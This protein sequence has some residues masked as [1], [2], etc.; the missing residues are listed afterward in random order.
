MT[1]SVKIIVGLM[2]ITLIGLLPLAA[3]GVQDEAV[4]LKYFSG[5]VETVEWED[6]KIAEFE[7][8]NPGI[9][10]EHEFQKD[11]SNVIK[12]KLASGEM[13]DL[14]TVVTQEFIDQGIYADL[15]D[16]DFWDRIVPSV[17]AL[18]TDLN[19]GKQFRVATNVTMGGLFYNKAMFAELGLKDAQTWDEFTA[20]L[21]A[22][23]KAYPDTDPLFL[24][25]KDSWTLGHFIEFWAHG[26]VKQALGIPG[27]RQAFLDNSLGDLG[28]A[29]DAPNGIMETFA[30]ALLELQASE[31][32]NA[33]AVTATYDNQK[34]S[35][36]SGKAA[37]INQGMWVVGDII[38]LNPEMSDNIGFSPFPSVVDGYKPM[39]L[40]AEDSVWAISASTENK[41]EAVNFLE[42]MFGADVQKEYSEIRGMPS[43]FT[44][45]FADWSPIKDDAKRLI[46]TYVGINF[47]TEA[48]S[49]LSVDDTG[50]LI[51]ELLTGKYDSPKEFAKKYADLW[52]AAY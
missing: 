48:P 28:L 30:A 41:D 17:K 7:A 46:D 22:I 11:A 49:A 43:A 16:M 9:K 19:T 33:D 45:V 24:G 40:S 8:A 27:S 21:K 52:N 6:M 51:Q 12:V 13:P 36:A 18:C 5:R 26:I 14:T 15:S 38:K 23:K 25:G 3:Q 34:E 32:I 35:F 37:M 2:L 4:T 50:R 1:K 42:F 10:I 20:N 31:L 29:W 44:D 39:V 47:S